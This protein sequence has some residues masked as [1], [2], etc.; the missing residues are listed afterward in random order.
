MEDLEKNK[1]YDVETMW[2]DL[3]SEEGSVEAEVPM[4]VI[5]GLSGFLGEKVMI[6]SEATK[7]PETRSK[8]AEEFDMTQA[9]NDH[10]W[11][12]GPE[13]IQA[14]GLIMKV[15]STPPPRQKRICFDS[16]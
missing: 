13:F 11:T 1:S 6:R 7:H 3:V 16:P 2:E 5:L 8:P 10:F 15:S 12:L 9:G 4:Q 14:E